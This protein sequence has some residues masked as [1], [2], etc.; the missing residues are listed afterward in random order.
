MAAQLWLRLVI[1]KIAMWVQDLGT[2]VTMKGR[3]DL[4]IPCRW[5]LFDVSVLSCMVP[6]FSLGERFH[7]YSCHSYI[8]GFIF[9]LCLPGRVRQHAC[10]F[11][12][13]HLHPHRCFVIFMSL[14]IMQ[15]ISVVLTQ[16]LH[17]EKLERGRYLD[18][19][20]PVFSL[21]WERNEENSWVKIVTCGSHIVYITDRS[22]MHALN[23]EPPQAANNSHNTLAKT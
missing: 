12:C 15:T 23:A 9:K 8:E 19:E 14:S 16:L 18:M 1:Y 11:H 2:M 3:C 7:L 4:M 13:A 21:N 10:A 5:S 17:R 20:Y 22:H 6:N